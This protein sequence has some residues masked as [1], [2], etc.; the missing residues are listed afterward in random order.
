MIVLS[1]TTASLLNEVVLRADASGAFSMP[2]AKLA[3]LT[4][5]SFSNARNF[6][7]QLC[8]V[9]VLELVTEGHGK[10]AVYRVTEALSELYKVEVPSMDARDAHA[11]TRFDPFL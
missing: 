3:V 9:G 11:A 10:P 4:E 7:K 6:L 1:P 8:G 2:I 5:L